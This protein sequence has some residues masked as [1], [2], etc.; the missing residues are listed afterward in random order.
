MYEEGYEMWLPHHKELPLLALIFVALFYIESVQAEDD[1]FTSTQRY[2]FSQLI[3]M[4]LKEPPRPASRFGLGPEGWIRLRFSINADGSTSNIDVLDVMPNGF[5]TQDTMA[6]V[7]NWTFTPAN[8]D[9][10]AIEWHNNIVVV[11]FD[12][13]EIPNISGPRFTG[14]YSQVQDLINEGRLD[15]AT[16]QAS[17]NLEE[18]TY[19]LHDIGLGNMQL[20]ILAMRTENIHEALQHIIR[21]TL[22]EVNQLT[23][24]EMDIALQYRFNIEVSLGRYMDALDTYER[25]AA[26]TDISESELMQKQREQILQSLDEGLALNSRGKIL[27]QGTGWFFIP[28]KRT[29]SIADVEGRL[30]TIVAVCN[31]RIIPLAYQPEVEW[32]LPQSWGE[33]SLTVN[34]LRN[35]TFTLFEFD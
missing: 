19:S 25:R 2:R 3:P 21:A 12:L 29:F 17:T 26:L 28:S 23:D 10:E 16:R 27:D 30:D 13:P 20:A 15:R 8:V 33:C 18:S 4:S 24:E 1:A 22:P 14:P 35:T 7:E 11:N 32:S 5:P 34:G 9:G 31:R 6:T